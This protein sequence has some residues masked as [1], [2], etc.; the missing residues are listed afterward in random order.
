MTGELTE[1]RFYGLTPYLYYEDV[2]TMIEWFTRVF[3]FEEIGR[4]ANDEG[5]I[6]NVEFRVGDTELWI[7]GYPG[8]WNSRGG[9]PEEWIGVWVDNV[10]AMHA[11][12]ARA[13]VECDAPVDR[14]HGV[15]ELKVV[16]PQGYVWGFM[17]RLTN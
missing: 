3:G 9:K 6:H 10:D 17:Q 14:P 8:Y 5:I 11:R 1:V 12:V 7:D 4:H 16:D 2:V 13:G 15:R